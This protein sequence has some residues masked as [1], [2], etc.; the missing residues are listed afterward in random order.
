DLREMRPL[1]RPVL[2]V[3]GVC[4][5]VAFAFAALQMRHEAIPPIAMR[6][7]GAYIAGASA[8]QAP[9]VMSVTMLVPYYAGATAEP[10]P[11][12]SSATALAY[13]NAKAPRYVVLE[14]SSAASRPYL[15]DWLAHGIPDP[16]ARLVYR[17]SS[18]R[19]GDIIVYSWNARS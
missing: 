19:E 16:R 5:M 1:G 2:A 3:A 6:K 11:Y 15:A 12:S 13:L 8:H 14:S 7:A 10:L 9:L 17:A 4:A 18:E